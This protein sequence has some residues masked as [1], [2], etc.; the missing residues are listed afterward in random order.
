MLECK[1]IYLLAC[2]VFFFRQ[3]ISIY[4]ESNLGYLAIVLV[5]K[6]RLSPICLLCLWAAQWVQFSFISRNRS[7][8]ETNF[9]TYSIGTPMPHTVIMS[10]QLEYPKPGSIIF[11]FLFQTLSRVHILEQISNR[12][13]DYIV[14][15]ACPD[16]TRSATSV[17]QSN[18]I[19]IISIVCR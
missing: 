3:I 1:K 12:T 8:M 17:N 16:E 9:H 10:S 15:T 11:N 7:Q 19:D 5:G 6:G 18:Y 2:Y 4:F 13:D 14:D